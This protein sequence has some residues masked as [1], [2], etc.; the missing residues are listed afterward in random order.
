MDQHYSPAFRE[1]SGLSFRSMG[2]IAV[3]A[4]VFF[5]GPI[6]WAIGNF[7]EWMAYN[8]AEG[9]RYYSIIDPMTQDRIARYWP[10]A[11][12]VTLLIN[13]M[14]AVATFLLIRQGMASDETSDGRSGPA[15]ED[16]IIR[17]TGAMA[18]SLIVVFFWA[19]AAAVGYLI[20]KN[21]F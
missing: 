17:I 9:Y 4:I 18:S 7:V 19:S 2:Q 8:P 15:M 3:I 21:L 10:W 5:S 13:V 16:R 1:L 14:L 20:L 12:R 6:F 11:V